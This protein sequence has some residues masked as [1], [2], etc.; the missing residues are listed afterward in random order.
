M[1]ANIQVRS[2]MRLLT[3]LVLGAA[4][5]LAATTA[6]AD[7][8]A[9]PLLFLNTEFANIHQRPSPSSRSLEAI[10]NRHFPLVLG[11]TRRIG[12][13]W[14]VFHEGKIGYVADDSDVAL[15]DVYR[16]PLEHKRDEVDRL[17]AI[18]DAA[19]AA[20]LEG[21]DLVVT[22]LAAGAPD[23]FGGV[24]LE[25]GM[26]NLDPERAIKYVYVTLT[27]YN[28]VGDPVTCELRRRSEVK[29]EITGPL[30]AAAGETWYHWDNLWY[31]KPGVQCV[32]IGR[33]EVDYLNGDRYVYV[34][35]LPHVLGAGLRND[36]AYDAQQAPIEWAGAPEYA[37]RVRAAEQVR[38]ARFAVDGDVVA[39][40]KT[41]LEW[42]RMPGPAVKAGGAPAYCE[43]LDLGGRSDW[44]L[45]SPAE[46]QALLVPLGMRSRDDPSLAKVSLVSTDITL[47]LP[48][49]F[50]VTDSSYWTDSFGYERKIGRARQSVSAINGEAEP[51][52]SYVANET[53]CVRGGGHGQGTAAAT[54]SS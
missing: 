1:H 19:E 50:A 5:A 16:T 31:S 23:T 10:S 7:E 18:H 40:H 14:W 53:L 22:G 42:T 48:A 43:S 52:A 54:G 41:G 29:V 33:I 37:E 15:L 39:D 11:A 38:A 32:K 30:D 17:T 25:F 24:D 27:P 36:C 35:E 45:P 8:S 6:R 12:L 46:I 13:Y 28:A 3:A 4:A 9:E 21:R 20:E 51:E 49:I 44:R 47:R 2:R 34:K 26:Q